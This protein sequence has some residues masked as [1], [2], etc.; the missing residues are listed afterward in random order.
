M[1]DYTDSN[2]S[3]FVARFALGTGSGP[4]VAVKD[5]IDI[6]GMTTRCGSEALKD[7]A[8]AGSNAVVVD[9]LLSAGC[10]ILG[11]TRMHELAY[12][13]T[14]INGFEGTP[15]NPT[16]PLRIPGG[17]SS[18]SAA[19]VARGEVDFALGTDTGGS[20]RQPAICCGVIGLKPTFGLLDRTGVL[21][22]ESSLDCVGIFARSLL[23]VEFAMSSLDPDFTPEAAE[24][25]LRLACLTGG[26]DADPQMM[27]ACDHLRPGDGDVFETAELPLLDEAFAAGLTVIARETL[28]ANRHL[29]DNG[30]TLG[31]DVHGRLERARLVTEDDVAYAEDVRRRFTAQVDVLLDDFDAILT[32]ALPLPPPLLTE[33]EDPAKV[34]SLTRYLRPFNLSGHP[35]LVLPATT[36]VGLPSGVQLIGRKGD[37]ARLLA[38]ARR[39]SETNAIFQMEG[40]TR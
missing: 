22:A 16:W 28:I 29:L 5:C 37:D 2:G 30:A 36:S 11:K 18:G 40:T 20:V 4:S 8:S 23:M 24:E 17:S 3:A 12:G 6:A 33:A 10:R 26:P 21:P 19:A 25:G 39:L 7:S 9:R 1:S 34:L 13:M 38:I 31:A 27:E 15:L 35:A 14:G 32:P